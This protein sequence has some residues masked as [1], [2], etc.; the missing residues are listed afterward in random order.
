MF[1][2]SSEEGIFLSNMHKRTI[3]IH[4][5]SFKGN[6]YLKNWLH[7]FPKCNLA[8]HYFSKRNSVPH[9]FSKC[10]SAPHYFSKCNLA[11]HYFSKCEVSA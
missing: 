3:I 9:Y 4:M 11:P 7:Y 6:L 8:P 2:K 1:A 5:Q 10:N